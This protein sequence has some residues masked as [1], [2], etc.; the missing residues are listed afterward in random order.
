MTNIDVIKHFTKELKYYKNNME[1]S[2]M[3]IKTALDIIDDTIGIVIRDLDGGCWD[4]TDTTYS[5]V[6]EMLKRARE[7][8][9]VVIEAREE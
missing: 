5:D 8:L 4:G 1:Y 3:D 7:K 9:I 2:N 6:S